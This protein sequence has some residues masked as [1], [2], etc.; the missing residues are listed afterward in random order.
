M[1]GCRVF[2]VSIKRNPE[3][4]V[5]NTLETLYKYEQEKQELLEKYKPRYEQFQPSEEVYQTEE[6]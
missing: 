5:D 2:F 1:F 4:G 6:N 3:Y